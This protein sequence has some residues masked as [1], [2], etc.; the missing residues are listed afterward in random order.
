MC[1]DSVRGPDPAEL[2]SVAPREKHSNK[3]NT[4]KS[5]EDKSESPSSGV[6]AVSE[7]LGAH[8]T[9]VRNTRKTQ[10]YTTQSWIEFCGRL[11]YTCEPCDGLGEGGRAVWV[12]ILS[13][14][15][16]VPFSDCIEFGPVPFEVEVDGG[17]RDDK[18]NG[19]GGICRWKRS[20]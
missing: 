16:L 11:G 4:S 13:G 5:L 1:G 17:G 2:L 18:G 14:R 3:D 20:L 8:S 15:G 19:S 9:P 7:L 12:E 10:L 6:P